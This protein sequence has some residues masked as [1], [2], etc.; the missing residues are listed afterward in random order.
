MREHLLSQSLP[1][2]SAR[3]RFALVIT[4]QLRHYRF[5]E[6]IQ[7]L[8]CEVNTAGIDYRTVCLDLRRHFKENFIG[9]TC[10]CG[11]IADSQ[12]SLTRRSNEPGKLRR[13]IVLHQQAK[14]FERVLHLPS[15]MLD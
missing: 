2:H 8:A 5:T 11:K 10:R 6:T 14:E 9:P 12:T 1:Q 15:A 13:S 7:A 4:F 3:Q